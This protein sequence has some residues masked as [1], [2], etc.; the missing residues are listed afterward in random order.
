M[1]IKVVATD[2][3]VTVTFSRN[4]NIKADHSSLI[5]FFCC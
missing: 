3:L 2:L 4:R 5:S 1:L